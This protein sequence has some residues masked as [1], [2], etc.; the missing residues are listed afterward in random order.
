MVGEY[1][2][3]RAVM[4]SLIYDVKFFVHVQIVDYIDNISERYRAPPIPKRG[5]VITSIF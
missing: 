3:L 1:L 5:K 4:P 2:F